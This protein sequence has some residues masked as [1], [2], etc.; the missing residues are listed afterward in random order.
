MAQGSNGKNSKLQLKKCYHFQISVTFYTITASF[1]FFFELPFKPTRPTTSKCY[2]VAQ[3]TSRGRPQSYRHD[4][5]WGRFVPVRFL[6][7]T[8]LT[9][10][11]NWRAEL[12]QNFYECA[13]K[14]NY[15]FTLTCNQESDRD[16]CAPPR[17]METRGFSNAKGTWRLHQISQGGLQWIGGHRCQ[18]ST[19][20]LW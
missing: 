1:F 14:I 6:F 15:F 5:R 18:T 3:G 9:T 19:I 8:K 10:S 13:T 17:M 2:L 16:K 7:P 20:R 11:Q 12:R 4:L